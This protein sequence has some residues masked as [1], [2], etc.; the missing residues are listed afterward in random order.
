MAGSVN[1]PQLSRGYVNLRNADIYSTEVLYVMLRRRM[2]ASSTREKRQI[3]PS[4]ARR[5]HLVA[6]Q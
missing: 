6:D 4:S 5:I 2:T 1:S 3:C